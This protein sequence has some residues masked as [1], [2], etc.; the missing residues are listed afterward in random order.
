M[1]SPTNAVPPQPYRRHRSIAGPIVLITLGVLLL[2]AN[3][4]VLTWSRLDYY[5]ERFWPLLIILWGVI[6]L[7]EY[8][9][10]R[11]GGYPAPGIGA[12]GVVLIVFVVLFGLGVTGV[13]RAVGDWHRAFGDDW[14]WNGNFNNTYDMGTEEAQQ[15]IKPGATLQLAS[16]NGDITISTWDQPMVKVVDHRRV[17]AESQEDAKTV[18]DATKTAIS[19]STTGDRVT[20]DTNANTGAINVRR[21]YS[22][23]NNLEIFLPRGVAVDL[24]TNRGDIAVRAR[25]GLVKA[26]TGRGDVSIEDVTGSAEIST[27]RGDLRVDAVTGDVRADGHIGDTQITNIGGEV[28]LNADVTGSL[29]MTKIAK[30]VQFTSSRTDLRIARLDGELNIDG[31]DLHASQAAGPVT[32][33]TR[34]KNVQLEDVSGDLRVTTSNGSV[35]ITATKLPLGNMEINDHRGEVQLTLPPR[36]NFTLTATTTH[37]DINSEFQGLNTTNQ[38]RV[39][40]ATGNV[41]TGG[42]KVQIITD[43]GDIQIHKI[44]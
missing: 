12:G 25:T 31:S 9:A 39:S 19:F 34:S 41:G 42:P 17:S 36:A 29:H 4:G 32:L 6:K 37:G 16:N 22:V 1:A 10:A 2:L 26:A 23:I 44:G 43:G 14:N 7:F 40:T 27:R 38:S 30:G 15:P 11:R 3:I 33:I 13:H 8:M 18:A 24:N 21:G 35:S 5:F 20:L 28:V